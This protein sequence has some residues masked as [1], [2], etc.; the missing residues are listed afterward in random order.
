MKIITLFFLI[1]VLLEQKGKGQDCV[2]ANAKEK[3]VLRLINSLPEVVKENEYRKKAN[4]KTPLKAFIQNTPSKENNYYSV[5]VTEDLGVQLRT[6][7]WYEVNPRTYHIKY[8]D[9]ASGKVMSLN[10]WRSQLRKR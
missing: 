2:G 9:I 1:F 5:S 10:Q 6:Y 3:K 8:W 4:I 7:D